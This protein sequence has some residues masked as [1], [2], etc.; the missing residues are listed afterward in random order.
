MKTGT[1]V[2]EV[3]I[4]PYEGRAVVVPK[5]HRLCIIDVEGKQ[6]GDFVCFLQGQSGEHVSP[7]HMRSSLS[8]IRLKVGD[9]LYSNL[10]RPLMRLVKDTVGKHDFFF[11]A[12][13]D[14]RY[15]VDFG[16]EGH[17]NCH[18]NL[19]KALKPFGVKYD[20]LPDPINWFMNNALDENSDYVIEEPLSKPGDYVML[21][22]L[23]DVIVA[24]SACSQ[25]MAPVNGYRVTPLKLQILRD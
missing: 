12:C 19:E 10:R 14:Y 21:E 16:V 23:W 15:K 6:V 17:P 20:V 2:E 1:I 18:D 24:V 22:A 25:D 7:V 11:P 5:G 4:P 3:L 9:G 8:S 13:D